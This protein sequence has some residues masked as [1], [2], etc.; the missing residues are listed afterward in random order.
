M[1][2]KTV[3]VAPLI[4]EELWHVMAP[5]EQRALDHNPQVVR[6]NNDHNVTHMASQSLHTGE[7]S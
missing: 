2:S 4:T 6:W 1:R 7:V 5:A 3:I